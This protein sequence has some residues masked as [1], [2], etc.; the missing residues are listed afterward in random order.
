[1][2][3]DDNKIP[4]SVEEATAR[5]EVSRKKLIEDGSSAAEVPDG[6]VR[7]DDRPI[8]IASKDE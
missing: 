8:G 4:P 2:D 1:M 6:H 3:S 5:E 7:S